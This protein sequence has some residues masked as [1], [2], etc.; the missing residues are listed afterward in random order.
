MSGM[1]KPERVLNKD[2]TALTGEYLR[3]NKDYPE[4]AFW[5]TIVD[6][7]ENEYEKI[8]DMY[9]FK[10]I[11]YPIKYTFDK[12]IVKCNRFGEVRFFSGGSKKFLL[13]TGEKNWYHIN[14][15]DAF[16]G[17]FIDLWNK[18]HKL[19]DS[20]PKIERELYIQKP[21]ATFVIRNSFKNHNGTNSQNWQRD[22]ILNTFIQ[23]KFTLIVFQD[24]VHYPLPKSEYII[25]ITMDNFLDMKKLIHILS[26]TRLHFG[27][28]SG[29]TDNT[30]AECFYDLVLLNDYYD[31]WKFYIRQFQKKYN[32]EM[33][34]LF[35][36]ND[37]PNILS[38]IDK[39]MCSNLSNI[40]IY[41]L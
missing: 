39:K 35:N 19:I 23:K 37:I 32:K 8:I 26:N 6:F 22:F 17:A 25:E 4:T 29:I 38:V 18:Y 34:Y 41:I 31:F 33:Y 14:T 21:Y 3:L 7:D 28:A 30:M 5:L 1:T 10:N 27:S 16:P 9:K 11:I 20:N 36:Q 40:K 24:I 15:S 2:R 13:G 12:N